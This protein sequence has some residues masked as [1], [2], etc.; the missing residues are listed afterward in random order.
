MKVMFGSKPCQIGKQD[1]EYE[2]VFNN[3][4]P[5]AYVIIVVFNN[6]PP[7]IGYYCCV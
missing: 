2:H 4:P 5:L 6:K 1:R 7:G 3:N